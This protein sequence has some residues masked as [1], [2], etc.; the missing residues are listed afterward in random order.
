MQN[1]RD[2]IHHA[3]MSLAAAAN[4]PAIAGTERQ[5]GDKKIG[6]IG[7]DTSHS[8]AFTKIIND[9]SDTSMKGFSVT[10]AYRYGSKTIESSASR[11]PQYT[12]EMKALGI[13][14]TES[15]E[16]LVESV[17]LIMLMTNDGTVHY[18]QILPVLEA[19]KPVFVDKPVAAGLVDVIR[20]FDA[21]DQRKIPMFSSSPLRFIEG[22]Q[23]VRYEGVVGDVIGAEA[24]SPQKTEP[25]HTDLYWYGI[26]GVEILFTMMGTG[27]VEVS[28]R[29]EKFQ[30]IVVGRWDDGRIGTYRGDL[31]GRQYY[32]GTAYGTKGVQAVGP[33]S[34]YAPLVK[35][36]I[37]FF[38][39]LKPPVA[40]KE[41]LE[42]YTFMEAADESKRQGGAWVS[43]QHVFDSAAKRARQ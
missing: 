29:I 22:A 28:R 20:I 15:L 11:I 30:D 10:H 4:I 27:C 18:Q 37:A 43:L 21:V 40:H 19:G 6:L 36:I 1:R 32:G 17:D 12:E 3:L 9:P 26:H 33:F 38:R 39:D 16:Q 14:I 34:G 41:T 25:S 13:T 8:P 7:L 35:S 23:K 42:L 2:F 24:F 5:P 31:E